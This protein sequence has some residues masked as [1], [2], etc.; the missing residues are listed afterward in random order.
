MLN[1]SSVLPSGSAL[2]SHSN[3]E[4]GNRFFQSLFLRFQLG[5]RCRRQIIKLSYVDLQSTSVP[6]HLAAVL[7]LEDLQ[8]YLALACTIYKLSS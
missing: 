6:P 7:H 3:G 8:H 2:S 1:G 5:L 4:Q